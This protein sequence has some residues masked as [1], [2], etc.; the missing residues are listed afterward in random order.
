MQAYREGK[1]DAVEGPKAIA[2]LQ[3]QFRKSN[4]LSFSSPALEELTKAA[5]DY[6]ENAPGLGS[7][8]LEEINSATGRILQ[9]SNASWGVLKEP[10]RHCLVRRFPYAIIYEML[11]SAEVMIVS[12]F[13]L[14][15]NLESWNRNL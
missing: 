7:E 12:L 13:H 5:E 9:F 2:E 6:D 11:N 4:D 8:F 1:V 15:R 3:A 10:L 14:H